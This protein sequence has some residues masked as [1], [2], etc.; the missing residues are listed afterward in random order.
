MSELTVTVTGQDASGRTGTGSATASVLDD[1]PP[2]AG[3]TETI[4]VKVDASR[5]LAFTELVE[6]YAAAFRHDL[7]RF[8]AGHEPDG[9]GW[10][11]REDG[12]E[13]S[14]M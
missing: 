8:T 7:E 9:F 14:G 11:S 5:L 4:E 13:G 12:S 3:I 2:C 10:F 1:A 6:R